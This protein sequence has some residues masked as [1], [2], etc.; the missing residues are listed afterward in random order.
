MPQGL[1]LWIGFNLGKTDERELTQGVRN[2]AFGYAGNS[3]QKKISLIK[4]QETITPIN[5]V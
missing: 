3:I 4:S 2:F 5:N 1:E